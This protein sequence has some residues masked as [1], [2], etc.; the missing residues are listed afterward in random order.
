MYSTR[1]SSSSG[2]G[3]PGRGRCWFDSIVTDMNDDGRIEIIATSINPNAISSGSIPVTV[4]VLA[5]PQGG[6]TT[7]IPPDQFKGTNSSQATAADLGTITGVQ[8]E[9]DLTIDQSGQDEW[10]K[11]QT[12]GP[13]TLVNLIG[14]QFDDTAGLLDLE[15]TDASG[16]PVGTLVAETDLEAVSL[17][18]LPAGEYYVRVSG[19]DGATSPGYTLIIDA[20]AGTGTTTDPYPNGTLAT[21]TDLN[22]PNPNQA[23]RIDP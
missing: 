1:T 22:P 13:S 20:P 23:G 5:P 12:A 11:F 15:V 16:D 21:A 14:I 9:D 10:F 2:R 6:T 7:T 3:T 4:T 17:A 18:G 8:Q 19:H